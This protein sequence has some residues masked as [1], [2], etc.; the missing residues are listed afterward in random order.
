MHFDACKRRTSLNENPLIFTQ[1]TDSKMQDV[2]RAALEKIS[3][4]FLAATTRMGNFKSNEQL[5]RDYTLT[6]KI[7]FLSSSFVQ[8]ELFSIL[9]KSAFP[10]KTLYNIHRRSRK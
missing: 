9:E 3:I 5:H 7:A 1:L 4:L 10:P 2:H 6:A 8:M